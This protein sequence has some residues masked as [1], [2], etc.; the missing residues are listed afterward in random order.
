LN[1]DNLYA[2]LRRFPDSPRFAGGLLALSQG[3]DFRG[4][5]DVKMSLLR[6]GRRRRP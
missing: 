1:Q 6:L 4:I 5:V 3:A 2:F